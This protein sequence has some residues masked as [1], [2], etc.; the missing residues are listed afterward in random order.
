MRNQEKQEARE[1][2]DRV[3]EPVADRDGPIRVRRPEDLGEV[4]N[5]AA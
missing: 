1:A 5:A 4:E 3:D 2:S